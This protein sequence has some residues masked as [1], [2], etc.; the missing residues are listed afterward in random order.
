VAARTARLEVGVTRSD[1]FFVDPDA[2][3]DANE[4]VGRLLRDMDDFAELKPDQPDS[5]FGDAELAESATEF[6]EKWQDGIQ[7]LSE[8]TASIH[9][10]L[11]DTIQHYRRLDEE[12]AAHFDKLGDGQG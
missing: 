9:E 11:T 8:D 7:E 4:D 12:I 6:H 5:V 2:L 1:G 3:S 10:R